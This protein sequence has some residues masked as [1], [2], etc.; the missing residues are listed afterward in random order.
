[1]KNKFQFEKAC[2]RDTMLL[3]LQTRKSLMKSLKNNCQKRHSLL[4]VNFLKGIGKH[5][6]TSLN[7][8][9]LDELQIY[10]DTTALHL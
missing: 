3:L 8:H 6:K 1:M 5:L 10:T 9:I 2:F 4:K 7:I